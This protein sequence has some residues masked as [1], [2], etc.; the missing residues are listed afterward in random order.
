MGVSLKVNLVSLMR[1]GVTQLT[2]VRF[3]RII[4]GVLFKA[5]QLL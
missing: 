3:V 2:L 1:R 4:G 5:L